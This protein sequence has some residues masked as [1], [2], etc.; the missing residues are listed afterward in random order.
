MDLTKEKVENAV[1]AKGYVWFEDD[2]NKG[3]GVN[4]IGIRNL[5][6]GKK[7]TNVFDDFLTLSYKEDGNWVFKQW[8][9]TTD[10]GTKPVKDFSNP[11]G[12]ARVVPGQYTGVWSIGLHKG[13]Y[14]ALRQTKPIKVFRDKNKDMTFV[15]I[16]IQQGLFGIHLQRSNPRTESAWV[17]DWSEGCQVFKRVKD[18][19]E[20][21]DIILKSSTIHGNSF[22]YTL[23]ESSDLSV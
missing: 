8:S 6:S 4:I 20:F 7:V 5:A 19:N 12:V 11:N 21:M 13:Q 18:F 22:S 23:L 1:K 15:E 9:I 16:V 17:E 10:P 3:Y 14:Q 2:D